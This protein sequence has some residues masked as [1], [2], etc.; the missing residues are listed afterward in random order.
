MILLTRYHIPNFAVGLIIFGI[1]NAC[2]Y[3]QNTYSPPQDPIGP[4]LSGPISYRVILL[5]RDNAKK[6]MFE[7]SIEEAL[8]QSG[9]T[10]LTK[11][12]DEK[13]Y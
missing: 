13:T 11:L 10:N 8:I 7:A 6:R 5:E 3:V 9:Y 4:I 1:F 12:Q 2:T